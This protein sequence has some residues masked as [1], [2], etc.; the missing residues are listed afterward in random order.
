MK[1]RKLD[2]GYNKLNQKGTSSLIQING[3]Q[4]G[5]MFE[6]NKPLGISYALGCIH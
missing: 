4:N 5:S 3:V 1:R 2:C 6:H